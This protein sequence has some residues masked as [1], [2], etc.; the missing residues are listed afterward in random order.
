M[1]SSY[2][3]A[4][5]GPD[6]SRAAIGVSV[7]MCYAAHGLGSVIGSGPMD[8]AAFLPVSRYGAH[9]ES[10]I[11]LGKGGV[12]EPEAA[13]DTRSVIFDDY[14]GEICQCL[15]KRDSGW[16]AQV[17]AKA[18][19]PDIMLHEVTANALL[20]YVHEVSGLVAGR[21]LDLDDLG[22]QVAEESG[23]EGACKSPGEIEDSY[24]GEG[25]RAFI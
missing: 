22:S 2:C 8:V 14:V 17:D 13:H 1:G 11:S 4:Y 25:A 20:G 12:V 19:F 5:S 3:V 16:Q 6:E 15:R 10:G 21:G 7:E 23:T 18:L 24:A 9:H